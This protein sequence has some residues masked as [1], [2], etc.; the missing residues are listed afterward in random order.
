MKRLRHR[1]QQTQLEKSGE[2]QDSQRPENQP[3]RNEDNPISHR[4]MVLQEFEPRRKRL[5]DRP[6]VEP[7]LGPARRKGHVAVNLVQA[8]EGSPAGLDGPLQDRH[9]QRRDDECRGK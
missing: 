7:E 4:W 9:S 5:D 3:Q 6:E 8:C 2:Q 1:Q